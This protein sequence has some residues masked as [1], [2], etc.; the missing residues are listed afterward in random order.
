[1]KKLLLLCTRDVHFM[2]NNEIYQQVDGVVMGSPLGA[3]FANI[4]MCELEDT[5]VPTL[6]VNYVIGQDM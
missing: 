2:F 5:V 4:F 6:P 3:L 1:M